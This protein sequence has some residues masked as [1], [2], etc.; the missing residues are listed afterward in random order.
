MLLCVAVLVCA[1][2]PTLTNALAERVSGMESALGVTNDTTDDFADQFPDDDTT[3]NDS[4]QNNVV[5]GN[6]Q[7]GNGV[8]VPPALEDVTAPESVKDM[9]GY[10]PVTDNGQEIGT[11][12]ARD[13]QEKLKTGETGENLQFDTSIYP[14][15][16]MLNSDMQALYRQIYA[17]AMKCNTSFAPIKAVAVDDLKNVFEAVYNDHPELFWLETS[18]ACKYL[19]NGQC[20]EITLQYYQ[21]AEDLEEAKKQ[22]KT[23]AQE[24]LGGAERLADDAEKE[25]YVHDA[26]IDKVDYHAQTAMGQSAYSALVSGRS[27]CAGYARAFQYLMMELDIPCYYCAG[28]SGE[29]HAWNIV[30]LGDRYYNVDVTWDDTNPATLDYFNKTDLDYAQTHLRRGMSVNLPVCS[31]VG[32]NDSSVDDLINDN[33]QKPL[34]WVDDEEENEQDRIRRELEELG[35]K[36]EDLIDDLNEYYADCQ[37]QMKTVGT[38]Q[39]QFTCIIPKA[40]WQTIERVYSDG[41]YEK[42]YVDAALKELGV[43]NFAIQLQTQRLSGGKYYRLYHNVSTW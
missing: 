33:P 3:G 42:G 23:A 28:Y 22:F 39:Q 31:T 43:E 25:R 21:I 17:N 41:S 27:V 38:G 26:L 35:L 7:T 15:Y 5:V 12:A 24:I 16:G 29:D 32:M 13:L 1:F 30:K 37:K 6:G 10:E 2:N 19:K 18:Y 34:A 36:E 20:I 9:I 8:Y 11:D 40:L 4:P 14:Y